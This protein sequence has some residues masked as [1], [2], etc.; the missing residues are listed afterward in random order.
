MTDTLRDYTYLIGTTYAANSNTG[1]IGSQQH[2]DAQKSIWGCFGG[3]YTDAGSTALTAAAGYTD[4][5]PWTGALTATRDLVANATAGTLTVPTNGGGVYEV[6]VIVSLKRVAFVPTT[7]PGD[8]PLA[9]VELLADASPLDV[10]VGTIANDGD[11]TCITLRT[12]A[13]L[14]AGQVLKAKF[15]TLATGFQVTFQYGTFQAKR[16]G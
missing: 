14:T 6:S 9:F 10:S 13:T 16:I 3:L 2:R 8:V 1:A 7:A 11:T 4:I 12:L 15:G 5:A